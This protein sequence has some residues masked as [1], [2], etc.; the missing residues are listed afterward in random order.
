MLRKIKITSAIL[1]LLLLTG[2]VAL[3]VSK[4]DGPLAYPLT[5]IGVGGYLFAV[6]L[7]SLLLAR[8]YNPD[9]SAGAVARNKVLRIFE[10][11]VYSFMGLVLLA[12]LVVYFTAL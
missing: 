3:V 1:G 11:G 12:C 9:Q 5:L 7:A 8:L 2:G 6:G 4:P 10:I